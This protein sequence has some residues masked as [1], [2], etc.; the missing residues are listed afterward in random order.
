MSISLFNAYRSVEIENI[1][2]EVLRSGQIASGPYVQKFTDSFSEIIQNPHVVTTNDMSTAIQIALHLSGVTE[3][4]EVLTTP[5]ACMSTNSPIALAKA[6]AVWVDMDPVTLSIDLESLRKKITKRTKA[7]LLY[8]VAGYP[9]PV[10]EVAKICKQHGITLI[11]DCNNALMAT[12]DGKQ[13]GQW[14]DFSVFSFYPNRQ[15][16]AG[17]GG[18]LVCKRKSDAE[19]AILLR[20]YGINSKTFRDSSGE[21][22]PKSDIPEVGW[23]AILNNLCSA[24]GHAQLPSLPNRIEKVRQNAQVLGSILADHKSITP[25]KCLPNAEASYWVY[26]VKSA[27]RDQLMS[28]L[29]EARIGCSKIHQLNNIYSGFQSSPTDLPG[30]QEVMATVLGIPCGWWLTPEDLKEMKKK[31][32]EVL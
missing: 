24:M 17:E 7:L 16:N 14:G 5:Y 26:M 9:G 28:Q 18:A 15:I 22:N 20:R 29:K 23:A 21:I 6:K 1:C 12:Y 25:I 30:S 11:E 4:D 32:N 31:L 13:V 27:K 8:H 19:R 10:E 3:A 2:L